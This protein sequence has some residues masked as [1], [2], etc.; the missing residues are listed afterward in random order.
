H[1]DEW[2]QRGDVGREVWRQAGAHGLLGL[3]IPEQYGG[4]GINDYRFSAVITEESARSRSG[5]SLVLQ[6]DIVAPYV[7]SL[8]TDEQKQRWLP[9]IVTGELLGAIAM[10]EPG[11]GS[12]LAGIRTSARRDGDEWILN[13]SKTFISGGI[14]ADFV[15][16]VTRTDPDAGHKGFTLLVVED[17][18]PGFER[19]KKLDKIG[20]RTS[21]TAELFF[22][23]VRVPDSNRLGEEGRGF[24]ALMRNLP[25]ER[26]GIAVGGLASAERAFEITLAYAKE[27]TAFGQPIGSF[28]ANRFALAEMHTKL[29]VARSYLD[30]CIAS[31]AA[32]ELS[33][34][35]AAGAKWWITEL[36]W[37][38]TD[39]CMQ[40]FG[41]YGYIN[42]YEI[43]AIWRDARVQRLYGGTTEIMKDLVGRKL[44]L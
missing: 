21:D 29:Q 7:I 36:Q 31:V 8:G 34:E 42:E 32:G 27:R 4:P 40:L 37:D 19:G 9:G 44:G 11:A 3:E 41:G 14:L 26:M 22:S 5:V 33:A 18:M 12:D 16:V 1:R 43:A 17:G 15:I 35:D 38:I 20:C 2:E 39:R 30:Q 6:N 28:Q 13:G 23:D 24:Y 10:S 25:Q